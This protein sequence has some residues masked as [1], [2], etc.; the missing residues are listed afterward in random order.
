MA[1]DG[2]EYGL[3]TTDGGN[4][5]EILYVLEKRTGRIFVYESTTNTGL[6]FVNFQDVGEA[7]KNLQ[8]DPG[9]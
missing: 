7:L 5:N 3:V 2:Q 6:N 4:D 8:K 1:V 9:H